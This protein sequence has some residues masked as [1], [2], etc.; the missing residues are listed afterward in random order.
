MSF[1]LIH[2]EVRGWG[3]LAQTNSTLVRA[4]SFLDMRLPLSARDNSTAVSLLALYAGVTFYQV[5]PQFVP[6]LEAIRVCRAGLIWANMTTR[7]F[8]NSSHVAIEVGHSAKW[9]AIGAARDG[10][11]QGM[12]M[13]ILDVLPKLRRSLILHLG[14]AV[15]LSAM[16]AGTERPLSV[17]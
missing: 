7:R 11:K 10:T 14:M 3:E 12:P 16:A 9:P 17:G 5:F 13:D 2:T 6:S 8:M 1:Q 4:V 15:W